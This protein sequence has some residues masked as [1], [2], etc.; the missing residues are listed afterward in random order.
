MSA[1]VSAHKIAAVVKSSNALNIRMPIKD[2][3]SKESATALAAGGLRHVRITPPAVP[4][5]VSARSDLTGNPVC[6]GPG[7]A[8][9]ESETDCGR[10]AR[11]SSIKKNSQMSSA[12]GISRRAGRSAGRF[13]SY[14]PSHLVVL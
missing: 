9:T 4:R 11:L 3:W 1:C 5:G 14:L 13:T 12:E 7:Q 2:A 10:L 8:K 6:L